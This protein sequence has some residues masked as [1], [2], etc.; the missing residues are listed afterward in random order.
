MPGVPASA[1]LRTSS[2]SPTTSAGEPIRRASSSGFDSC[3][4]VSSRLLG[5]RGA[6]VGELKDRLERARTGAAA[7]V[8][9]S[10]ATGL[11][12]F[13]VVSVAAGS[14]RWSLARFLLV[15]GTGRLLR[16]AAVVAVP[17][18]LGVVP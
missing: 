12:P 18:L 6:R 17:R 8:F 7:V 4:A 2:T 13:Y 10:A 15:G 5:R 14:L 16:F 3:G 11:P 1:A 9:A